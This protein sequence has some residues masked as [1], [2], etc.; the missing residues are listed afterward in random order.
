MSKKVEVVLNHDGVEQLL[1]SPEI[2]NVLEGYA[3]KIAAQ[4]GGTAEIYVAR[5]RAVAEVDGDDGNNSALKALG[6]TS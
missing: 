5:T 6:R 3:Q 4:T 2:Q 1:K